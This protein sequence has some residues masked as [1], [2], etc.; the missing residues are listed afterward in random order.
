[1]P[2]VANCRTRTH[3]P[4][5]QSQLGDKSSRTPSHRI[6]SRVFPYRNI[7]ATSGGYDRSAHL[8]P[9]LLLLHREEITFST[10]CTPHPSLFTSEYSVMIEIYHP[11]FSMRGRCVHWPCSSA[12]PCCGTALAGRS[13]DA[14]RTNAG[15]ASN[16]LP[17]QVRVI[18]I[19]ATVLFY[20]YS[21]TRM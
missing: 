3:Y 11:L 16:N 7:D 21:N 17:L 9:I 20:Q 10:F 15:G 8:L 19:T 5:I 14:P 1:M 12:N 6:T 13:Q 4:H 2:C 18:R